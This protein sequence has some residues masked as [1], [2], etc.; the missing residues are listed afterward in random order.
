MVLYEFFNDFLHFY[1]VNFLCSFYFCVV[2]RPNIDDKRRFSLSQLQYSA[3][4]KLRTFAIL[5]YIFFLFHRKSNWRETLLPLVH[6]EEMQEIDEVSPFYRNNIRLRIQY[7]TLLSIRNSWLLST[8]Q[9]QVMRVM[10]N[11]HK[12]NFKI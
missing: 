5:Q 3:E 9:N 4:N 7:S 8:T 6:L 1:K 2:V 12:I 11:L 10:K